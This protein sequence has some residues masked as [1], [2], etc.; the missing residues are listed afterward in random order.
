MNT[1]MLYT[2][3]AP[4]RTPIIMLFAGLVLRQNSRISSNLR[5]YDVSD[6]MAQRVQVLGVAAGTKRKPV[7]AG[8]HTAD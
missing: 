6:A 3:L 4:F 8:R 2:K 7:S 1:N 5:P